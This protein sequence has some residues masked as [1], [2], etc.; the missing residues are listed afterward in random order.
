MD[1]AKILLALVIAGEKVNLLLYN[2]SKDSDGICTRKNFAKLQQNP[3]VFMFLF[4][5]FP[6]YCHLLL[7]TGFPICS[8]ALARNI[9]AC[10]RES[11]KKRKSCSDRVALQANSVRHGF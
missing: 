3:T 10:L 9:A 2:L 4:F 8:S 5:Y 7:P 1:L 6:L 11:V